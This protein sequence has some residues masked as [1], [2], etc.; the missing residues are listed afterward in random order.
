LRRL[1]HW[2]LRYLRYQLLTKVAPELRFLV[3]LVRK[4]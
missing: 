3:P 4:N 1:S 2:P